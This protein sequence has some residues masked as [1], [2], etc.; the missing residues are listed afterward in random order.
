MKPL[1]ILPAVCLT[2]LFAGCTKDKNNSV[3]ANK[4]KAGRWQISAS[5]LIT[6]YNGKDTAIDYYS[7]WLACEQDDYMEFGDKG[8][9]TSNENSNKCPEDAQVTDFEWELQ[10]NDTK[11]IITL[12]GGAKLRST[13]NSTA[14]SEILELESTHLKLKYTEVK[15]GQT[16]V[17]IETY[18]NTR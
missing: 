3:T 15:N 5:V 18:K 7:G 16:A 10:E 12:T 13:G 6:A 11:L 1:L 14:A 8:K 4:L 2:M 17:I 9:G